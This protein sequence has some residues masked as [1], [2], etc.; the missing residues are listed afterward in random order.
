MAHQAMELHIQQWWRNYWHLPYPFGI[1][2]IQARDMID[3]DEAI[4]NLCNVKCKYGKL[5]VLT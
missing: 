2:N 5:Y 3:I 1:M 4:M